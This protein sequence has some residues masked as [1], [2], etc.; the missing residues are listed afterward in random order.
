[1]TQY[2]SSICRCG[3]TDFNCISYQYSLHREVHPLLWDKYSSQAEGGGG[4]GKRIGI[5]TDL[6]IQR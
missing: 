3:L 4:V 6:R 2:P 5:Y 1:M